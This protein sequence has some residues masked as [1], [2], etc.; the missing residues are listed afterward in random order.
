[1]MTWLNDGYN[2]GDPNE[3]TEGKTAFPGELNPLL[4]D[5][6]KPLINL[7]PCFDCS[8]EKIGY[9]PSNS[10]VFLLKYSDK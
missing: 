5:D 4:A 7:I 6:L 9:I 3:S 2:Y 8:Q 1:M 10:I